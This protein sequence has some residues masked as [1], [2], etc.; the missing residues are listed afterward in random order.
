MT[1]SLGSLILLVSGLSLLISGCGGA[2]TGGP[3]LKTDP[4]SRN[5]GPVAQAMDLTD[6]LYNVDAPAGKDLLIL[7]SSESGPIFYLNALDVPATVPDF[8]PLPQVSASTQGR[9]GGTSPLM[10]K[11]EM[12]ITALARALA[13]GSRDARSSGRDTIPID[14]IGENGV[15]WLGTYSYTV[16]GTVVTSV[17]NVTGTLDSLTIPIHIESDAGST[18]SENSSATDYT[19]TYSFQITGTVDDL[20]GANTIDLTATGS[21][22][23]NDTVTF[24]PLSSTGEQHEQTS[25][26][27]AVNNQITYQSTT[28]L[29]HSYATTDGSDYNYTLGYIANA[30][31]FAA[32]GYWVNGVV[33]IDATAVDYAYSFTADASD[34]YE[35]TFD[36]DT[37]SLTDDEGSILANLSY[38]SFEGAIKVDFIPGMEALGAPDYI[39]LYLYML[40]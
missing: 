25:Y 23:G 24:S 17:L 10:A 13:R 11:N 9:I 39:Y 1:K 3:S 30:W 16:S 6:A 33:T 4:Y 28:S 21:G 35:L 36:G 7:I 32:D 14:F 20:T 29:D 2:G 18:L 37:G 34:G 5:T 40:E 31:L 26:R 8:Y 15:H 19:F 27:I 38:D 22:N 12:T